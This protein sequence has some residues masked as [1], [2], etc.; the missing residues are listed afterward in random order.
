[1]DHVAVCK[2]LGIYRNLVVVINHMDH[3]TVAYSENRYIEVKK[4]I[5]FKLKQC[6]IKTE[7]ID[8]IPVSAFHG[9]NIGNN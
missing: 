6:S 8:F 2:T 5:A 1:M 7:E 3:D 4:M 9:E